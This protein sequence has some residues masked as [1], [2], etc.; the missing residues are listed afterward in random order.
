MNALDTIATA[1][2]D[3]TPVRQWPVKTKLRD[4]QE[5]ALSRAF[6]WAPFYF[7]FDPGGGKTLTAIAEAGALWLDGEIDTMVV[8][9][10]PGVH[11][12]WVEE[13]FPEHAEFAWRGWAIRAPLRKVDRTRFEKVL[14]GSKVQPFLRVFAFNYEGLST[15]AGREALERIYATSSPVTPGQ[16]KRRKVYVVVDEAQRIKNHKA[17]RTKSAIALRDR[18]VVRR[19]LS[20][21]PI[22]KGL[23]DLYSQ[24]DALDPAIIGQRNFY[25]FRSYYCKLAPVPNNPRAQ[26]IV[27]Y[28]NQRELQSKIAPFTARVKKEDMGDLP[29]KI[30]T[31]RWVELPADQMKAYREME[32]TFLTQLSNGEFVTASSALVQLNKL[33]QLANGFIFDESGN[34]HWRWDSKLDALEQDLEAYDPAEHKLV[35]A[36]FVP[37]VKRLSERFPDA[38]LYRSL[39]QKDEFRDRGGLMIINPA[40]GSAGLDMPFC[41]RAFNLTHSDSLE[42][43]LQSID[44]I[45]RLSS[46]GPTVWYRDYIVPDTM[47]VKVLKRLK[48]K[49]DL[50]RMT[51]DGL[52]AALL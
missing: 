18:S 21:T 26:R 2:F 22:L 49:E 4:Y 14:S 31:D 20:G 52:R 5:W 36:H 51:I 17:I 37:V 46:K 39:D 8:I 33:L 15:K 48:K 42:H 3:V 40:K 16:P 43:R 1:S 13:A 10:P 30:F 12:Q 6:G 7:A 41:Q 44:R 32:G 50:G 11:R 27:G 23:E 28:R 47:E 34:P 9:A 25:G 45:H 19:N 29:E 38:I 24:Y 35:W